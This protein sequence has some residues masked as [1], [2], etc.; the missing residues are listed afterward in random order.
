MSLLMILI[1]VMSALPVR[2][3]SP[4]KVDLK[5]VSDFAVLAGSTITNT[6]DTTISG[7]AGGDIG[8][9]PGTSITGFLPGTFTGTMHLTDAVASQAQADL[10]LAYNDAASRVTTTDLTGQDLGGMTLTTG[11]YSFDTSA[12]LTGTLTL[13]AQ[14]DPGAVFIFKID[15]T[16]TTATSAIVNLINEAQS[17]WVY[18]QVGS[19]ATLGINTEFAG[20]I[21]ALTS[22][23]ANTGVTVDG[24]LLAINGAVTLDINTIENTLPATYTVTFDSQGGS[25]VAAITGINAGETVTVPTPPTKTGY[26]F[27]SWNTVAGGTGTSFTSSTAVSASI[28]V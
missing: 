19:S 8:V 21:F 23:T 2:A 15:S 17:C 26:A 25:A 27:S 13:D 11:V 20:H 1:I 24:Q 16:L 10:T 18:W 3:A 14:G 12:Q 4:M 22:I 5:T 28:T 7:S 6:G 9:Y